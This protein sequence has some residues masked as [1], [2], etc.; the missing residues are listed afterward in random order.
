MPTAIITRFLP[1]TNTLGARVK[2]TDGTRSIVRPY[3]Y[4]D[5]YEH[6]HR[7]VASLFANDAPLVGGRIPNGDFAWFPV[8]D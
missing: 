3:D 8:Q 6:N 7:S 2:A 1:A 4:G 5:D